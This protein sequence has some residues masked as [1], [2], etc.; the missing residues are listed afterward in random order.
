MEDILED[1]IPP[2]QRASSIAHAE[3]AVTIQSVAHLPQ[4]DRFGKCDPYVA[5][6]FFEQ[7]Y[8]TDVHKNCYDTSFDQTFVV[9]VHGANIALITPAAPGDVVR[10]PSLPPG[11]EALRTVTESWP[12]WCYNRGGT[13]QARCQSCV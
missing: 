13:Q 11:L 5:L 8:N 1:G 3:Y 6:T 7:H 4:A 2:D 10:Q 12:C 9:F